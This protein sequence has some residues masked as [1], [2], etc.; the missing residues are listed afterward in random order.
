MMSDSIKGVEILKPNY[1]NLYRNAINDA[2]C[3][4]NGLLVV[5]LEYALRMYHQQV[6]K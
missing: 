6:K 2:K 3:D 4:G 1:V 5:L